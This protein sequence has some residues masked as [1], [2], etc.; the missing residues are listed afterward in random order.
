M[1]TNNVFVI[2]IS[3]VALFSLS[4]QAQ[5]GETPRGVKVGVLTCVTLPNTGV[6]LIIH[7][8]TNVKCS[9]S[10]TGG[11]GIEHYI[12]ETGVGLG[13]E[14]RKDREAQRFYTVLSVEIKEGKRLAGT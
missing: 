3:L 10:A 9:F 1:K 6:S 14:D 13:I 12:G 4:F 7:S 8:T 2:L 11:G 5:A